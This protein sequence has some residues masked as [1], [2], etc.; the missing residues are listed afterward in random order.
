[1]RAS[2]SELPIP[3]HSLKQL[4]TDAMPQWTLQHNPRLF[5]NDEVLRLYEN[6]Y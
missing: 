2:L 4:A 1:M 3:D 5:N 6:A